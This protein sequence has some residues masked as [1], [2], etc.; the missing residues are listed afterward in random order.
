MT[1]E[2]AAFLAKNN[3]YAFPKFASGLQCPRHIKFIADKIQEK[4][5]DISLDFKLLL[6]SLPPRHG[7][8]LL[9]S[10]HLPAWYLG[11]NPDK[12]IILTSYSAELSDEN[13]DYAKDVFAKWGPILW[14]AHP[15]KS[16]YNR[17]KWN[18][19]KSGGCISAGIGGSITGFGADL[20]I[21]DDYF[22]GPEEAQSKAARDKLWDKW[23]GIIGTRLHPGCLVIVLATRW[24]HDDLMGR[25]IDKQVIEGAEFPFKFEYINMP[26]LIEDEHDL[27]N[28]PLGRKIGE[29]LWPNRF[30]SKLL[31]NAKKIV[32]PYWWNAEFKGRPS[33]EGG[34]LF[35]SEHFRYYDIDRL[36]NDILCWRA[37]EKD[38]IR[39]RRNEMKICVIVD[40][41]LEKKTKND[42][43]G[44]H[45]WAYSRKHKVWMLLDRFVDRIDHSKIN[46]TSK[47]FAY[48]NNAS[49]ILVE[50]EKLGKILVKQSEGNDK[51]GSR[52]IPF[53]EVPT[54]GIDKYARAT[55]MASYCE[56]ERVFFP[57]NAPWLIEFERNLKDFPSGSHDE[58][59]DLAAYASTMEDKISIAEALAGIH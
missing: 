58:D 12:R 33:R 56:N 57:K 5:E 29:A 42:P 11:R 41:A 47:V 24:G 22:K 28:D 3:F 45:A 14:D 39:V 43:T 6:I 49:Y 25:L 31:K 4:L 16:Y 51:I 40:P 23:Q 46:E 30:S 32:G 7:K 15:S 2:E 8:T 9:I 44:M 21:I 1:P 26:A 48:K 34:N 50:N 13:S 53:K 38:P 37:S 20:F 35:K 17:S 54:K 36:T 52:K 10:K 55:P 59:V 18:T 27:E 19:T